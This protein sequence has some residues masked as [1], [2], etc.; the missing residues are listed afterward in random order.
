MEI[1]VKFFKKQKINLPHDVAIV[2]TAGH[3]PNGLSL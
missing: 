3:N 2:Y 1:T